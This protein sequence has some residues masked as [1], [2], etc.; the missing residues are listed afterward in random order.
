MEGTVI[1][2]ACRDEWHA[3]GR[4]HSEGPARRRAGATRR[5]SVPCAAIGFA[6]R[7]VVLVCRL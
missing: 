1:G 7:R 2:S 3:G 4:L 6:R 5:A